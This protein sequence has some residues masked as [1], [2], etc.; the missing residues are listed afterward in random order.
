[1]FWCK[2]IPFETLQLGPT[3]VHPFC[4]LP[5]LILL[6]FPFELSWAWSFGLLYTE[7]CISNPYMLH[8]LMIMPT[9]HPMYYP[10][11]SQQPILAPF[12]ATAKNIWLYFSP[13]QS[14]NFSTKMNKFPIRI[15]KV[16]TLKLLFFAFNPNKFQMTKFSPQALSNKYQVLEV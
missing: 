2:I 10:P 11:R 6:T 13:H 16:P 3:S 8:L 1:M 4:K 14:Y 9:K 12:F 7:H 15:Y 5:G